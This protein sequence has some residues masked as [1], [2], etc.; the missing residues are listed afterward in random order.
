MIRAAA[1]MDQYSMYAACTLFEP[2]MD[3]MASGQKNS[4]KLSTETTAS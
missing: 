3:G 2:C 4:H 1:E